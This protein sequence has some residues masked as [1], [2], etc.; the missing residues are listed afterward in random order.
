M[1]KI[2]AIIRDH[3]L[4]AVNKSL[5]DIGVIGMTVHNVRGFGRQ[6][7]QTQRYRGQPYQVDFLPKLKTEIV[8]ADDKVDVVVEALAKAARTGEI[9]DGKIFV[10]P[11]DAVYRIRTGERDETAL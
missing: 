9:G 6:K 11:V 2:T 1:K 3:R 8:V 5:L 10:S 7:G 4:D